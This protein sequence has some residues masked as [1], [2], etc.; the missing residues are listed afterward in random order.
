MKRIL[1]LML[2]AALFC[3]VALAETDDAALIE[4][5]VP[6]NTAVS[7][8]LDGDG[9]EETIEWNLVDQDEY[10]SLVELIVAR[11]EGESLV[12]PTEIESSEA[13]Y[14]ADL[15]GDGVTEIFLTGD[16]ASDDYFTVCL[17]LAGGALRE[18]LFADTN[19]GDSGAGYFKAGYGLLTGMDPAAGT[20]TLYGS[21][22][23]LG[24]WFASRT[25]KLDANGLFEYADSGWWIREYDPADE[26]I[27]EYA[28]LT[29]KAEVPCV[30]DGQ[31]TALQPGDQLLITASDKSDQA[32]FITKD[33]R[34]GMLS[35]SP[36][37]TRGWGMMVD[38]IPEDDLFEYVPYAD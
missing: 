10:T 16:V 37:Y 3:T 19:R 18:V 35:I 28:A 23:V 38:N 30:I 29:A 31:Q 5:I 22:D 25:L 34:E 27:W 21:Q 13:V 20:V 11:A 24:T 36:D 7:V 15:D 4:S 17:H 1:S 9:A 26:E 2:I 12:Y 33:G 14:V 32:S 8:D 6:R